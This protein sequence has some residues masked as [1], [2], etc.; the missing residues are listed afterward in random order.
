M[1][2]FFDAGPIITL[3]M[4]RLDWILPLLKKHANAQFYITP[5]VKMEVVDRPL[6][7]KRFEFEALQVLKHIREGTLQ[8]YKD[9]PNA[10]V[11]RLKTIAN[12]SFS[13]N[14]KKLDILQE[15]ELQ[16][17]SS[18]LKE[19][20]A[21]VIDERTLRLFIESNKNMQSLL[22]RRFKRK[23][24]GNKV[25]MNEFS[26]HYS[27][28]KIIRSIELVGVAYKLGLL[29]SYIPK[30]KYGRNILVDSVLWATK[31]NGCAVT[32]HE[33]EELERFLLKGAVKLIGKQQHQK[34]HES[35][36]RIIKEDS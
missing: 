3:V 33:V 23:V 29:D 7:I 10:E 18:A 17:A 31:F 16:S 1:K 4:S 14:N 27:K 15:G 26:A 9:V 11:K 30:R 8:I 6:R 19:N 32:N 24:D 5:A 35:V 28:L 21:V 22:G 12:G 34:V 36:S 2:L 20:A 25:K 13:I